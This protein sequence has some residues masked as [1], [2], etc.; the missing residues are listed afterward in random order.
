MYRP[1]CQLCFFLCLTVNCCTNR[2]LVYQHRK[3]LAWNLLHCLNSSNDPRANNG[4]GKC[5][6]SDCPKVPKTF[7]SLEVWRDEFLI[8]AGSQL[9]FRLWTLSCWTLPRQVLAT[10]QCDMC[11]HFENSL[12]LRIF[13]FRVLRKFWGDPDNFPFVVLGNKAWRLVFGGFFGA[14]QTWLAAGCKRLI[15]SI[16]SLNSSEN[17]KHNASICKVLWIGMRKLA[18]R[19]VHFW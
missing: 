8:Q 16:D 6:S 17:S 1:F 11:R 19:G 5:S 18:N 7:E 13:F 2:T 9:P 14:M 10:W 15:G 12:C 4:E 3:Y